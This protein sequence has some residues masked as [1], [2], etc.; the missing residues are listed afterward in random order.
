M[1]S[2]GSWPVSWP[3]QLAPDLPSLGR[4][5]HYTP[6]HMLYFFFTALPEFASHIWRILLSMI[7]S[8]SGPWEPQRKNVS[9][10]SRPQSNVWHLI[11]EWM[12]ECMNECWMNECFRAASAAWKR[13]S[14][15]TFF[16]HD[17]WALIHQ[18]DADGDK[19]SSDLLVQQWRWLGLIHPQSKPVSP[20]LLWTVPGTMVGT[21]F[22]AEFCSL[23]IHRL[24]PNPW[25]DCI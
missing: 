10:V 9:V 13:K 5:H 23:N 18:Q 4:V 2:E 6:S 7:S 21:C 11:L 3:H 8:S 16:Y 14:F 19:A 24:K 17:I 1:D 15:I 25:C 20:S 22:R 12:F